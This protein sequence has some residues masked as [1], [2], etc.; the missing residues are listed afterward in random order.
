MAKLYWTMF[1][2]ML[3]QF[4]THIGLLLKYILRDMN[5]GQPLIWF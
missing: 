2:A 1:E 5:S 4:N 3:W